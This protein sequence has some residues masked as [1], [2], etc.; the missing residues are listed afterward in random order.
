MPSDQRYEVGDGQGRHQG[1]LIVCRWLSLAHMS[2]CF[3][4]SRQQFESVARI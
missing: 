1:D 4:L 2:G 3:G